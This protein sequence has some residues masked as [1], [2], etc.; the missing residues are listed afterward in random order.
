MR[1]A[2]WTFLRLHVFR[3]HAVVANVRISQGDDLLTVAW[4]GKNCG[5]VIAVLNTTSPLYQRRL[6][7][8]PQKNSAISKHLD[9]GTVVRVVTCREQ[10]HWVLSIDTVHERAQRFSENAC[11]LLFFE[12]VCFVTLRRSCGLA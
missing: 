7:K 5:S 10:K 3:I 12:G 4:I 6:L 8:R 11:E 2:T 9:G 1:P